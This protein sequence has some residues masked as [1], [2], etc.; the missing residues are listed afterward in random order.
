MEQLFA[1][2]LRETR[3]RRSA[4]LRLWLA[5]LGDLSSTAVREWGARMIRAS[6]NLSRGDVRMEGWIQD[7]RFGVRSL[8][9]RPGFTAAAVATLALGIGATVSIFSV[10]NSVLLQ[11]L[12][13]PESDRLVVMQPVDAAT[14]TPTSNVD[15]P[16]VRAWQAEVPGIAITGYSRSLVTLTGLG[17]PAALQ[18]GFVTDGLLEPLGYAP[19]LGRDLRASDDTP[20]GPRVAVVSHG[21]WSDRLGRDPGAIGRTITL[22]GEPWE[23]V[24]VAPEDFDFPSGREVWLP[25]RHQREGCGHGCRV[26]D[27]IGKLEPGVTLESVQARFAAVDAQLRE[28]FPDSHRDTRTDLRFLIDDQVGS[29]RAALWILFG[30]VGMVLLIAC[31]N[32][33]N[34]LLVRAQQRAGEVALRSTLGASRRRLFRQLLTESVLLALP[35]GVLGAALAAWGTGALVA[36][37]PEGLPRLEETS[38]DAT[39]LLFTLGLVLSVSVVFGLL[40]AGHLT[41][42]SLA[43][44][45]GA[46]TRAS[47]NRAET[48]ARSALLVGEVALSLSLL[49]GAG[50]LFRTMIEIRS[51]E[52]GFAAEGVE[53][54]RVTLP[55]A[56]Y[57]SLAV[58]RFFD[59]LEGRLATIP[60]VEA[61]GSGFGAPF[62]AGQIDANVTLLD[63]PEVPDAD[64]PSADIRP[65]TPGYLAATG[66]TLLRGS[67]L[68]N[69]NQHGAEAVAVVNRTMARLHYPD[70][71]PIGKQLQVSANIGFSDEPPRTIV[72]VV[73]DVRVG[74][75]IA[76]PEPAIYIPNAQF[77][78]NNMYVSLRLAPRRASVIPEVR[79]VLRELDGGLA[80]TNMERIEDA[81]AREHATPLFYMT[82]LAVFSAL[83][84]ILTAVGLYG[85]VAYAVSRRTAEIGIRIALG[86]DGGDI[87]GMVLRQGIRPALAGIVLGL[88]L[89]LL[90]TGLLDSLL[91]GIAPYDP[92]TLMTATATLAGVVFA[93]TLLPALRASRI[94]PT[95]ALRAE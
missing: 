9:R 40:P 12:P 39:A 34:L 92:L 90:G 35:A 63:R 16:D 4:T 66:M 51:V 31:A 86:A 89:S 7:V 79:D 38:L 29:V 42:N 20:D 36:L 73:E 37:A 44:S 70:S 24:G 28:E 49:L 14:G 72:G 95:K 15:H 52:L 47:G 33:A 84:V 71:D 1:D 23:I 8:L 87:S 61:V 54:F 55:N 18:G 62:A 13:Y 43:G 48:A 2:R 5:A 65:S 57:D 74:S 77:A 17:D 91:Y 19:A 46:G 32:V 67:W 75:A 68:T 25:R 41:G 59:E 82:L 76:A 11:P 30:A 93:A 64:Q 26:L 45:L 78:I 81:V 69:A 88:A 10:V 58:G 53:R 83:A 50:L 21:F 60:G 94:A 6:R 56:R 85:V 80:I 27:A 3:G 22:N